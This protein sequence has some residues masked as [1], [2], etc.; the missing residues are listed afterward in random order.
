M[1]SARSSN[2]AAAFISMPARLPMGVFLQAANASAA[3]S[4]AATASSVESWKLPD[5]ANVRGIEVGVCPAL[6]LSVQRPPM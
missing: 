3:A 5:V 1:P 2:K 4:M 6:T